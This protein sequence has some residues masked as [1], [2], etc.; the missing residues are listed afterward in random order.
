M[1]TGSAIFAL[2]RKQSGPGGC[3][4][5]TIINSAADNMTLAAFLRAA[6]LSWIGAG[7][8]RGPTPPADDF[9]AFVGR[10][11]GIEGAAGVA[12]VWTRRRADSGIRMT[13]RRKAR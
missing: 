4:S 5:Q 1:R 9:G 3:G 7:P 6:G 8:N 13:A 10:G 11:R 12:A 2:V